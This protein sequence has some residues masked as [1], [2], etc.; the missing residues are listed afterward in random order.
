MPSS[1]STN[2][3]GERTIK[4]DGQ[5][6]EIC[7]VSF[8]DA[9]DT[10]L[11]MDQVEKL[12]IV[13]IELTEEQQA[14]MIQRKTIGHDAAMDCA[15]SAACSATSRC[16]HGKSNLDGLFYSPFLPPNHQQN[17]TTPRA[18]THTQPPLRRVGEKY[19]RP[20]WVGGKLVR[21]KRATYV[22]KR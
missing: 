9:I 17:H 15:L 14:W 18:Y 4:R 6:D 21:Q 2:S 22:A 16:P 19:A 10:K 20:S 3:V 13:N 12:T 8:P 1:E 11:K 7:M 5:H